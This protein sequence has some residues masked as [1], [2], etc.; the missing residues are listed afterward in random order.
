VTNRVTRYVE[1]MGYG[2]MIWQMTVSIWSSPTVVP[3]PYLKV[4]PSARRVPQPRGQG[5]TLVHFS[6]LLKRFLWDRGAFGG[7]F[8]GIQEVSGGTRGGY[9][10]C[11]LCQKRLSL[12]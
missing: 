12:S 1:K 5:L 4:L 2:L 8:R 11:V 7:C 9:L 6:A 3:Q 10:R